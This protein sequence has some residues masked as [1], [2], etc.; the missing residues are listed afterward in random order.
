M[1]LKFLRKISI[2]NDGLLSEI[3]EKIIV[4]L[5]EFKNIQHMKL[6]LFECIESNFPEFSDIVGKMNKRQSLRSDLMF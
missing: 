3:E 6:D 5:K 1:D 4:L 2:K